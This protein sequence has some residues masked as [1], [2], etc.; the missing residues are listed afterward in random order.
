M[1]TAVKLP[2]HMSRRKLSSALVLFLTFA[3]LPSTLLAQ[4]DPDDDRT[5]A[6]GQEGPRLSHEAERAKFHS[7]VVFGS[8][9][10][11]RL[12]GYQQRQG[13]EAQSLFAGIKWRNIGPEIQGGRVVDIRAPKEDPASI[14]VSYA[15]GGLWRTRDDG[16]TWT[17]L[18]DG[19]SAFG[20]GAFAVSA[21]GKTLWV[22][23]GEANNQRTS[24][25]G[26]GIFKSA[27]SGK[28]W[29][30]MGLPESHH[31]AKIVLN[32][33][34]ERIVYAACL[35]H[36][37]S[38]NPERGVFKTVDGGRTWFQCLRA[39]NFTGAMDITMD[40]RNPNILF[41]SMYD[42]ERR[43][44][45][46]RGSGPGSAV[47]RTS[48]GGNTWTLVKGLPTGYDAG[49]TSISIAPNNSN[50]IYAFVDNQGTDQTDWEGIDEHVPSGR[51]TTRRFLLLNDETLAAIEPKLLNSFLQSA[52]NGELKAE[53]V[54]KDVKAKKLT[55]AQLKE[56]I[57]TK[58]PKV[59]DPGI[60]GEELYRSDDGG[61]SWKHAPVG[62]FGELG[63]Y[64]YDSVFV[65]PANADDVYLTGVP[66][67]RSTDG[68]GSWTYVAKKAHVDFH[69]IWN[70]PRQPGKVWIGCDG[71]LYVS[72]DSGVTTTKVNSVPVA[73]ATTLAVD[74]KRPYNV[75]IGLQDNGTMK[76]PSSYV[77]GQSDPFAWKSIFG[78][79]GSAIAV[80][81]RFDGDTVYVAYQFGEHYAIN[82][83]TNES[84]P[85]RPAPVKGDPPQR[86]NWISPI[87]VSPHAPD[88]L[89]VGAQRL[90]RSFN[91]GRKYEPISPEL[92]KNR[93][94]GNV[95]YS[96]IKDISESPVR[97]GLIYA[98][99]DDGNLKMTPDGGYQ[100]IDIPTPQPDK[101]VTRVVASK[102]D[103]NTVYVAQSGYREDD[104]SPYLWKSVDRGKTWK[105]IVGNLPFETINTVREDPNHKDRLYVGT[106][107]GV[108][109]TFDCGTIW[110]ALQGG[111]PHTPVHDL[112]VQ[113]R[114]NEIVIA[115]HS[116]SAWILS[117]KYVDQLTSELR[118]TDLKLFEIDD[119]TRLS[120]WGY[121]QKPRWDTSPPK[122][123]TV[124]FTFFAQS[125]GPAKLR[126]KDKSGKVVKEKSIDGVKGFNFG[127]FDV[128]LTPAKA[129]VSTPRQIKDV[130]DVL[131]DPFLGTRP[132]YLPTGDYTIE[133]EVGG[134]VVT[135]PWK[136]K[137]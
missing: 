118:K 22:G 55:F 106:D 7:T 75:Y 20:I 91:Q 63:G 92:T 42:R 117:L 19:Q 5:E 49:R 74:N 79:D 126:V 107:M 43:A 127:D 14:Y 89:Y 3:L 123:P 130:Q 61:K 50:R 109:V 119:L 135:Q 77:P 115:T 41:A 28:S 113:A 16:Q 120:S 83:L 98:G 30:W 45:N 134:K 26:T 35:G 52:T 17:S 94:N 18:F 47:Y 57:N 90:Y 39:N 53:D 85:I 66:L 96:T 58:Y 78:G 38:Q 64:Y 10:D 136:I 70:D 73:Q 105:S 6:A 36:L 40:P 111:L 62:H 82:Q 100:W 13:L 69:A 95:P 133:L 84:W 21:D 12:K 131:A 81:P 33:R 110:E 24:Y 129:T 101:W 99:C 1:E 32:P 60:V 93:P 68:G 34:D 65:N 132:T 56:K 103:E 31:I 114:E 71:G 46:Y 104:F 8:S 80:D 37:Y 44:W 2:I 128:E 102:W 76:G 23:T 4:V 112:V 72:Y 48:D 15:T 97:F 67:L 11:S 86:F 125:G 121:A 9:A 88:I 116:R 122:A 87:V 27:D 59:F 124:S 25:S 108:F 137:N 29:N 51:L 54:I